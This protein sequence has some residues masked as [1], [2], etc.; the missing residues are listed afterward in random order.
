MKYGLRLHLFNLYKDGLGNPQVPEKLRRGR[1]RPA[2]AISVRPITA[3]RWPKV[4]LTIALVV[5]AVALVISSLIFL[6]R[7]PPT[8]TTRALAPGAKALSALAA[9][10]EK[11]IAVLPFENL[12][13]EKENAYFADGVQDEI[14][15][16]LSRVADLKV[17]SRTSVM[18]YKAGPSPICAKSPPPWASRTC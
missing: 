5:S 10:P 2:S 7:A 3:P 9:I 17:I 14:L 8:T 6:N 4:V 1:R 13:N 12:S 18:Q 15:T 16:G 11:S